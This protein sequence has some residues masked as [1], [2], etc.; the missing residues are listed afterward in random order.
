MQS[1]DYL[2]AVLCTFD[3]ILKIKYARYLL[4][5]IRLLWTILVNIEFTT[6]PWDNSILTYSSHLIFLLVMSKP[7]LQ[8]VYGQFKLNYFSN[9]ICKQKHFRPKIYIIIHDM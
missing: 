9:N 4:T 3:S 1:G 6:L 5:R 2:G 7:I 8:Y